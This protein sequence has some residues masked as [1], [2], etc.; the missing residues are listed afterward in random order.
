MYDEGDLRIQRHLA[1]SGRAGAPQVKR[2][3]RAL[4][5]WA[6]EERPVAIAELA[7]SAGVAQTLTRSICAQLEAWMDNPDAAAAVGRKGRTHVL[8][9][10][11]WD[12]E[13]ERVEAWLQ[14]LVSA[15]AA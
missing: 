14:G 7:L 10:L 11:V 2:V 8:N 4:G 13:L 3:A 12:S 5:A 6:G 15:T 9:H 1:G